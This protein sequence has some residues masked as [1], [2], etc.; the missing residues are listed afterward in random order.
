[1]ATYEDIKAAINRGDAETAEMLFEQLQNKRGRP[2][3]SG[4][5]IQELVALIA[6]IKE[7]QNGT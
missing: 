6:K 7:A 4:E 2:A 5:R 3:L 1:M